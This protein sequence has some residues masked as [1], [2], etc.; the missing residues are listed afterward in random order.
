MLN[1]LV[2]LKEMVRQLGAEVCVARLRLLGD[3]SFDHVVQRDLGTPDRLTVEDFSES[4]QPKHVPRT[5]SAS[6]VAGS[7]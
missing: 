4:P 2:L 6:R 3:E 5:V 7:H 1:S